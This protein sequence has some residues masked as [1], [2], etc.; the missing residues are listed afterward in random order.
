MAEEGG[1]V[2]ITLINARLVASGQKTLG[3]LNPV[4]YQNPGEHTCVYG[5][6]WVG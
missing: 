3:F 5:S 2:Q 6:M 1:G 4:F